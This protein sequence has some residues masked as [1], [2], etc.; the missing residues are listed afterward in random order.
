MQF[1]ETIF[2]NMNHVCSD[3]FLSLHLW[4][5]EGVKAMVHLEAFLKEKIRNA[6]YIFDLDWKSFELF[7]PM[8]ASA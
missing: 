3:G 6:A 1:Y 8:L 4:S 2:I 5:C 7:L